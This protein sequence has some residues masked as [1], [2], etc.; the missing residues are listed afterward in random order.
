M[1][2]NPCLLNTGKESTDEFTKYIMEQGQKFENDLYLKKLKPK[3]KNDIV[4]VAESL[5]HITDKKKFEET[6]GY[7]K[8][9]KPIIYQGV[10]HDKNEKLCEM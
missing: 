7:M 8:N 5:I 10:L 9:G 6:V 2:N 4:K 3:F 1:G